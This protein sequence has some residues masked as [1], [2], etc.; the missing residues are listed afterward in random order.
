MVTDFQERLRQIREQQDQATRQARAA[1]TERDLARAS[2][3]ELRLERREHLEQVIDE[4]AQKFGGEVP[5]FDHSKSFFEGK[6]QIELHC[7]EILI[8]AQGHLG[9]FFSRLTFLL[10]IRPD[11]GA[12]NVQVKKTVTNGDRDP[13]SFTVEYGTSDLSGFRLFVEE[14]FVEFAGDFLKSSRGRHPK[15]VAN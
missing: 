14:Q 5:G 4:Y 7:D 10:D 11:V 9:K 15:T 13:S 1:E 2:A 6:Y 3:V 8:D 12:I